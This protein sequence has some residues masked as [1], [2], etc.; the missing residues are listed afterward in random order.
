MKTS[1]LGAASAG[2]RDEGTDPDDDG[3]G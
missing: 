2:L 1:W 3:V